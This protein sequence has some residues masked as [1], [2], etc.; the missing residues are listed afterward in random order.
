MFFSDR[1]T[2][3][4]VYL[5]MYYSTD[6]LIADLQIL[7]HEIPLNFFVVFALVFFSPFLPL[8]CSS[9]SATYTPLSYVSTSASLWATYNH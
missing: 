7:W 2:V 1:P 5:N 4:N 6:L 3:P 8:S 9:P